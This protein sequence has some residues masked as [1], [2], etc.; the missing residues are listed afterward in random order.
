M[1]KN[2]NPALFHGIC[3]LIVRHISWCIIGLATIYWL[4]QN[5]CITTL[6]LSSTWKCV[7]GKSGRTS[8]DGST[9]LQLEQNSNERDE[10]IIHSS[11]SSLWSQI[12]GCGQLYSYW[13]PWMRAINST[14]IT[15][16]EVSQTG[17]DG[18]GGWSRVLVP[19]GITLRHGGLLILK[20][21]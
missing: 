3:V 21:A 19:M 9:H 15:C 20:W 14:N 8:E 11:Y 5:R 16:M 13:P 6:L 2:R 1:N 18:F 7:L 12:I 10:V 4:S 17:S